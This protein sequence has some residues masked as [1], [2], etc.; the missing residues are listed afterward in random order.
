MGRARFPIAALVLIGLGAVVAVVQHHRHVRPT[1]SKVLVAAARP[2]TARTLPAGLPDFSARGWR[3]VG[4][5]S[6]EI[7]GRKVVTARYRRGRETVT[8]SRMADTKGLD[9]DRGGIV[10]HWGALEI[11]WE[12]HPG[13][14]ARTVRGGHQVVLSGTP[15]SESLRREMTRLAALAP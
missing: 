3:A 12:N 7:G 11:S 15:E 6:D 14:A 2:V 9:D 4:G 1:A 5:R 13:L 10:R 8:Y